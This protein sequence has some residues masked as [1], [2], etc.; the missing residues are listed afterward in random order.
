[1]DGVT[2]IGPITDAGVASGSAGIWGAAANVVPTINSFAFGD[3]NAGGG[4]L[5]GPLLAQ[6][7]N[8]LL[9]M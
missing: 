7:M 2:I 5:T 3:L 9:R 1:L 6:R 8:V 4:G